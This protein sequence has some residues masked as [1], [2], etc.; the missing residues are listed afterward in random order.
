MRQ[1]NDLL[2]KCQNLDVGAKIG[3]CCASILAY[4][5]DLL[6]LSS[7]ETHMQLLLDCCLNYAAEWK[8]EF[9][10]SK[11]ISYSLKKT[12]RSSFKLGTAYIPESSGF[13]YLGLPIGDVGFV[14][15]FFMEKMSRCERS[16]YSLRSIGCKTN[17]LNPKTIAFIYK[18]FC[19]SILEFG[20]ENLYL[21]RQSL[22]Q[23]NVRQNT[24]IKNIIG[25]RFWTRTKAFLNELK[26]ESIKQLYLKHVV[27]DTAII[28]H[29]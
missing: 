18:Q 10:A 28:V 5:D 9:N 16:L 20:L 23:L 4:C 2:V 8:L 3:N 1:L 12:S 29:S 25:L 26:I 11:S 15:Q 14:E 21:S 27:G 6:L 17:A 7:N 19:Q 13:I 22:N 24:L